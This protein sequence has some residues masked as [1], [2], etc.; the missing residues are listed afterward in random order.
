VSQRIG[1]ILHADKIVMLDKGIVIGIGTH[2]ELLNNNKEYREL[3]ISQL[4]EE[5]LGL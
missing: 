4:S 3:A 5:E 2:K 1:S